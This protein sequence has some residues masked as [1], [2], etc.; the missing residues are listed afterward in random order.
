[1]KRK[2]KEE[3][4]DNFKGDEISNVYRLIERRKNDSRNA[5]G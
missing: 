1:M 4:K 3:Y 5:E 2:R